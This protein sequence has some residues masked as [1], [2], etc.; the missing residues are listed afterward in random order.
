MSIPNNC[1]HCNT[2][3]MGGENSSKATANNAVIMTHR[4]LVQCVR[5]ICLREIDSKL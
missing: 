4:V 1:F 3:S 5:L 2:E